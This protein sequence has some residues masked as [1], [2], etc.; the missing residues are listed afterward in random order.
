LSQLEP[1][2]IKLYLLGRLDQAKLVPL[3]ERLLTDETFFDELAIAEDELTDQYLAN[4][5]TDEERRD[6]ETYFLSTPERHQKLRFARNLRRYVT[7]SI[8]VGAHRDD[9]PPIA[10]A[11]ET[12]EARSKKHPFFSFLPAQNPVIAYSLAAAVL[13]GFVGISWM[14]FNNL[15]PG[16]R[17]P[18]NVLVVS[19]RPGLTRE[20]GEIKS[21]HI[22]PGTG[23]V[24]LQLE[25]ISDEYESYRAELL[26]SERAGL[27]LNEN[28][29]PE[30]LAGN[31][32]INF[33]VPAELL[34]R[35]DYRV[36]LS[37]RR[38]DG[39]YEDIASY[40]FRVTG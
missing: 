33:T 5:L 37:G 39:N 7:N 6:F 22:P 17:G 1:E 29:K 15:T 8:E 19:L 36:K 23:S 20:A 28:F 26:T 38:T 30:S 2:I 18:E 27:L 31:K 24:Q 14:V 35:D 9:E 21:I 40:A 10:V 25:L 16:P 11:R 3:E 13:I 4:E 32:I 12:R 34:K